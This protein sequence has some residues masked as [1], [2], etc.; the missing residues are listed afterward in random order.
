[1]VGM[2]DA[3]EQERVLG[4]ALVLEIFRV[5]RLGAIAGCRITDGV[6]RRNAQARLIRDAVVI[7][8]GSV[9][10]LRRLKDDVSEV[11]E[12]FECGI[13]LVNYNDMKVSDQIEVFTIEKVA[14]TEL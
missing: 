12:G 8:E 13:G 1:M 14:A 10:S 9:A 7:W 11:R 4:R 2:L 5:P 3:I 6:V